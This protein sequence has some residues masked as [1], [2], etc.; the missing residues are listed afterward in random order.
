MEKKTKP[1]K[2]ILIFIAVFL[3][4]L[5][6]ID[7]FL[8]KPWASEPLHGEKEQ[9]QEQLIELDEKDSED[10]EGSP[11]GENVSGEEKSL[12]EEDRKRII[13]RDDFAC[14]VYLNGEFHHDRLNYNRNRRETL[15]V[16]GMDELWKILNKIFL[17]SQGEL[18]ESELVGL[19]D[20]IELENPYKLYYNGFKS[21]MAERDEFAIRSVTKIADDIY[22]FR[23]MI[24]SALGSPDEPGNAG[25]DTIETYATYN[26]KTNT[27]SFESLIQRRPIEDIYYEDEQIRVTPYLL[28]TKM[29]GS[30]IYVA[31]EV[32]GRAI[33]SDQLPKFAALTEHTDTMPGIIALDLYS[34]FE[35][36]YP[37]YIFYYETNTPYN[38]YDVIDVRVRAT[39]D[40][41]E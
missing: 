9:E 10:E 39:K 36:L 21:R 22:R 11:D 24:Y 13:D 34:D 26:K 18:D 31:V 15:D 7:V 40:G 33:S 41:T 38:V 1:I 19:V 12:D 23:V 6:A 29:D 37:G 30:R 25:H 4:V 17:V 8:R 3:I 20:S 35:R 2:V 16:E 27:V 5:V 32:F 28:E 14:P